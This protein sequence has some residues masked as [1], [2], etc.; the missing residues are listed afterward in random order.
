MNKP[1]GFE[2]FLKEQLNDPE[3]KKKHD[4]LDEEFEESAAACENASS[5]DKALRDAVS[6]AREQ[7]S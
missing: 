4:A 5:P 2:T 3:F 7:G 6:H 1:V